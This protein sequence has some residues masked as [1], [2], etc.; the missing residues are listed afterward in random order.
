VALVPTTAHADD[1]DDGAVDAQVCVDAATSGV[2]LTADVVVNDVPCLTAAP[3]PAEP[4]PLVVPVVS[5]LDVR[6]STGP[7]LTASSTDGQHSATA[8][9]LVE[10]DT[11]AGLTTDDAMGLVRGAPSDDTLVVCH[12]TAVGDTVLVTLTEAAW[13]STRST[14]DGD[15]VS[16]DG[17]SCPAVTPELAP[18]P[19][20]IDTAGIV[21]LGAGN[22]AVSI[23]VEPPAV[24]AD[25]T[26][27]V[28]RAETAVFVG[29]V[30]DAGSNQTP[31]AQAPADDD[32]AN[33]MA[34]AS[35]DDG[36]QVDGSRA[37]ADQADAKSASG[38]EGT[39]PVTGTEVGL[40]LAAAAAVAA[41][42]AAMV[43]AS[44][45]GRRASAARV[46]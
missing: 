21:Q 7:G 27:A 8:A 28:R 12:R 22:D 30:P 24:G 32:R 4:A 31:T 39:L 37:A 35:D 33:S 34:P 44:R 29:K 25:D 46:R 40:V 9:D 11:S 10:T 19:L 42:G 45:R 17:A 16:L 1:S 43:R 2:V 18:V 41:V 6:G 20:P 5:D 38:D 23:E 3:P 36:A 26:L 15:V 13:V 14:R